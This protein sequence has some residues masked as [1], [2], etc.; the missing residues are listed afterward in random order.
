MSVSG[1]AEGKTWLTEM[2]LCHRDKSGGILKELIWHG[3]RGWEYK[4]YFRVRV[5]VSFSAHLDDNI[6]PANFKLQNALL[7]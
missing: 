4:Y 2:G 3:G 7:T 6:L 1:T 5:R